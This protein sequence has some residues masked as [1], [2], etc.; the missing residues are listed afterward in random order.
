MKTQLGMIASMLQ[1]V[2]SSGGMVTCASESD[3]EAGR[4]LLGRAGISAEPTSAV[5]VAGVRRAI[6]AGALGSSDEGEVVAVISGHGLKS[7]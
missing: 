4:D 1:A 5:V 6:A 3:I 2:S 7:S